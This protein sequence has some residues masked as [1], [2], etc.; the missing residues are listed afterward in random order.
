MPDAN[1][2]H[3]RPAATTTEAALGGPGEIAAVAS[4]D[5]LPA[6]LRSYGE[7]HAR[8]MLL[9]VVALAAAVLGVAIVAAVALHGRS[10][11]DPWTSVLQD[12]LKVSYQG[13]V[14]GALAGLAKLAVDRRKAG[15]HAR[16]AH[17]ALQ[18]TYTRELI[19]ATHRVDSARALIR[20]NR[21]VKTWGAQIDAGI[22][23]ASLEIRELQ[24]E[25]RT[26]AAA[27]R[28]AFNKS[29]QIQQHLGALTSYLRSIIE[30]YAEAKNRLSELQ[31]TAE[32]TGTSA[33]ERR[34]LLDEVWSGI[35]ALPVT[36]DL[37]ADGDEY[38][39]FRK[40]YIVALEL[41]RQ[42]LST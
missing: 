28:P 15:V 14:L 36:A 39:A 22:V 24:H 6:P 9:G 7:R 5:G 21:S 31:R 17:G 26:W 25:L 16:E 13:L 38:A 41:M 10:P 34:E 8:L 11:A 19:A 27:G 2:V 20:A 33:E 32:A 30:E 3:P 18:Q 40:R 29:D 12:V 37:I 4:G 1:E 35:N 23:P 42:S